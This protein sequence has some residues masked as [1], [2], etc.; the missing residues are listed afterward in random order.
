MADHRR[1]RSGRRYDVLRV[2]EYVQKMRGHLARLVAIA[3][4]ERGLSATGLG[5]REFDCASDALQDVG[6]R[7]T[8]LRKELVH[9]A[10][11][12]QRNPKAHEARIVTGNAC[13]LSFVV[14][15][16]SNTMR[17]RGPPRLASSARTN[18]SIDRKSTRLN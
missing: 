2:V 4:V 11:H 14:P 9:D 8:G 10:S 16:E 3:A 18:G 13:P 7:D 12:K 17:A 1:A 5:F 6:H 15:A